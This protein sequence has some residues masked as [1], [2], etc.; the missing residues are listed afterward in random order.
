MLDDVKALLGF[1]TDEQDAKLKVIMSLA[2]RRL[3]TLIG[4][5]QVPDALDYVL[6]EVTVRRFNRIGSEGM[7]SH[8]VEGETISFEDDDFDAYADDI[9]AWKEQNNQGRLRFL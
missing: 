6:T 5:A 9:Q 8:S 3:C 4:T 2:E 7:N 1:D